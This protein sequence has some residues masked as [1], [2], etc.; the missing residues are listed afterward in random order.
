[1]RYTTD[2]AV[3]GEPLRVI[4]PRT[5]IYAS[6][7]I[8][9][10]LG[11]GVSIFSRTPLALDV[12]RDRNAL[13]RETVGGLVEN[14]YTLKIINMDEHEHSYSLAISGLPEA[15]LIM[16]KKDV[17]VAAGAV[18]AVPARVRIDPYDLKRTSTAITFELR[19]SDAPQLVVHEEAR[20]IGPAQR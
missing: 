6:I 2:N 5:V 11:V 1:V 12:L 3:H 7:L 8:V 9:L 17:R 19:A 18:L 20:F 10:I 4:R 15:T 14:I 13:Y 16:G